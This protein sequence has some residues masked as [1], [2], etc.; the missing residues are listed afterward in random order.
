MPTDGL[1]S[2]AYLSKLDRKPDLHL[3]DVYDP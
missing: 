1:V 3:E 2:W